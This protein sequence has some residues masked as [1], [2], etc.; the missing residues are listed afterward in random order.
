MPIPL[1]K[2]NPTL[3]FSIPLLPFS[4]P[5]FQVYIHIPLLL[6]LYIP[7]YWPI[8]ECQ[9]LTASI[10]L[11]QTPTENPMLVEPL[12][13]YLVPTTTIPKSV[14]QILVG[15]NHFDRGCWSAL[16]QDIK[17]YQNL[18]RSSYSTPSRD[19]RTLRG[20]CCQ[21]RDSGQPH[22]RGFEFTSRLLCF[23]F[24]E[25]HWITGNLG[26]GSKFGCGMLLGS[27]NRFFQY[28]IRETGFGACIWPADATGINFI[29]MT[30]RSTSGYGFVKGKWANPPIGRL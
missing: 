28:C 11:N 1:Y 19:S 4:I 24:D 18:S 14:W 16:L 9:L 22:H 25:S 10:R 21:V 17:L 27:K 29:R 12:T 5:L 30:H 2:H 7:S 8:A 20:R 23:I 3:L 13:A 26:C 15:Q 6:F